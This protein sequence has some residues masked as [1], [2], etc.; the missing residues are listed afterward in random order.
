MEKNDALQIRISPT[1]KDKCRELASE[2]HMN[3][4]EYITDLIKKETEKMIFLKQLGEMPGTDLIV[5][6]SEID[7]L[8]NTEMDSGCHDDYIEDYDNEEEY[9]LSNAKRDG[10]TQYVQERIS[11]GRSIVLSEDNAYKI[12]KEVIKRIKAHY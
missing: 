2:K 12:Q 3:M 11:E 6:D 8:V 7:D 9:Y 10:Y 1:L 5:M 4:S